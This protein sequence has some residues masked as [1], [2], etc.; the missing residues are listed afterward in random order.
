L[1]SAYAQDFITFRDGNIIEAQ[2]IEV[3]PVEIKYKN[4]D[5]LDGPT[6]VISAS[7]VLSIRYENGTVQILG[8]LH[9]TG[10]K[11]DQ[12]SGSSPYALDPNKLYY[13]ISF[14]PAGLIPRTGGA[15]SLSAEFTQGRF[16]CLIDIRSGFGVIPNF[17]DVQE[18][19]GIGLNFNYFHPSRIGGFYVGGLYELS[20]GKKEMEV[21]KYAYRSYYG[22]WI[23]SYNSVEKRTVMSNGFALNIGYKFIT[24]SGMYFR[25]GANVGAVIVGAL[26]IDVDRER[27]NVVR[28][29]ILRPDISIGYNF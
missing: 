21:T 28:S 13:G 10:N 20:F 4:Y 8:S 11:N 3:S 26:D 27:A 22:Y 19:F 2:V 24:Q 12:G 1:F 23:A 5:D 29:M 9:T 7:D 14:N 15:L 25:T 16:N 17:A 6:I 18:S